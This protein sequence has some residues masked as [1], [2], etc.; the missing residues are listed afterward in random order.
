MCWACRREL[1]ADA[2][3]RAEHCLSCDR[4]Y[5]ISGQSIVAGAKERVLEGS[6]AF[7][8][9]DAAEQ[10]PSLIAPHTVQANQW[11]RSVTTTRDFLRL[12]HASIA[13]PWG[14][15]AVALAAMQDMVAQQVSALHPR[16]FYVPVGAARPRAP[17]LAFALTSARAAA[18]RAA[19]GL[20]IPRH[21]LAGGGG[22]AHAGGGERRGVQQPRAAAAAAALAHTAAATADAHHNTGVQLARGRG[23]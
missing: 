14:N 4:I 3:E 10:V 23:R 1:P 11:T 8:H 15:Q 19:L 12:L 6:V 20:P 16:A 7:T 18:L 13:S 2:A 22:A 5:D 17:T 21:G 9:G